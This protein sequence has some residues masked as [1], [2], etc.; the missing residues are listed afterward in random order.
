MVVAL[1]P[2]VVD[3]RL[4]P[5]CTAAAGITIV[6]AGLDAL[7]VLP[8]SRLDIYYG[9]ADSCIGLATTRVGCLIQACR[10]QK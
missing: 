6:A 2:A 1:L 7:T 9:A 10:D 4:W 5:L 8:E 3:S